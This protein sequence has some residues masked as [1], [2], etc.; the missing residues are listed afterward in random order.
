MKIKSFLILFYTT[1]KMF[2]RDRQTWFW[3][4]VIP[5]LI[6]T[7]FGLIDFERLG[8][9]KIGWVDP[10]ANDLSQKIEKSLEEISIVELKKGSFSKLKKDLQEGGIDL[11]LVLPSDLPA[12]LP[13]N[14]PSLAPSNEKTALLPSHRSPTNSAPPTP[15]QPAGKKTVSLPSVKIEVWYDPANMEKTDPG[16]MLVEQVFSQLNLQL[17]GQK[18]FFT[19]EQKSVDSRNLSYLDFITPGLVG[20]MI[21]QLG[22]IGVAMTLVRFREQDILKR[23][24][25]TPIKPSLFLASLLGTRLLLLILQAALLII[26]GK[27]LFDLH[28]QA[29]YLGV[30]LFVILGSL[31]FLSLGFAVSGMARSLNMA[32]AIAQMVQMPMMFL[33]GVFFPREGF[34]LWL[35][36]VTDYLPLTFLAEGLRQTLIQGVQWPDFRANLGALLIWSLVGFILARQFFRWE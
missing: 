32:M 9:I 24:R 5:L 2:I 11:L 17:T 34:P 18:P 16:L 30:V 21:M 1:L 26:L 36:R 6:L 13:Q 7:I 12:Q 8:K 28:L 10:V 27:V 22:I 33:S 19:L 31:T 25:L 35:Q 14:N 29:H 20:M 15:S 23:L 4:L 3:S